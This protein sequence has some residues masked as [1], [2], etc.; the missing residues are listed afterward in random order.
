MVGDMNKNLDVNAR[1][2]FR[3]LRNFDDLT[4]TDLVRKSRFSRATTRIALAKLEGAGEVFIKRVG[5]AKLYSLKG[6]RE[7]NKK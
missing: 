1:K 3:I 5:M 7:L 6:E 2:V 4:I